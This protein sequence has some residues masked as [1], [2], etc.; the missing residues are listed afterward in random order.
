M[1]DDGGKNT[2]CWS[3]LQ[4]GGVEDNICVFLF[5]VLVLKFGLVGLDLPT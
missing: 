3:N 1:G 2:S 5:G 4:A